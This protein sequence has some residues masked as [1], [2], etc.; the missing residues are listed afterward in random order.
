MKNFVDFENFFNLD[1]Q[2]KAIDLASKI[3]E[4]ISQDEAI[5]ACG[6]SA[7]A[8][9]TVANIAAYT[10]LKYAMLMLECYHQWTHD[11]F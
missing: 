10:S 5:Q 2:H 8:I 3:A 7:E 6:L 1:C 11:Q 4:S 9:G